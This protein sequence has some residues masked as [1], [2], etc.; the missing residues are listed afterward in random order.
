MSENFAADFAERQKGHLPGDLNIE[1]ELVAKGEAKGSLKVT[2][3]KVA[4]VTTKVTK[5]S[6]S[7]VKG[8][9]TVTVTTAKGLA[10]A[11]GKVKV[12]LTKGKAKKTVTVT[13]K[14]GKATVTL[15][16]LAKGTWKVSASYAGST[17]YAAANAKAVKSQ[18]KK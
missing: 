18:V 9:A 16:K 8:K 11:T 14:S 3:G 15:P 12:T 4:K 13:L 1:W 2:K 10:K 7:K 6:T 17:T 5:A